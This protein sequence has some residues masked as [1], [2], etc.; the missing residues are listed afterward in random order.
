MPFPS[1]GTILVRGTAG[2]LNVTGSIELPA[3]L[4]PG[5]FREVSRSLHQRLP[6]TS[7]NTRKNVNRSQQR[8][9]HLK[10]SKPGGYAI[11]DSFSSKTSLPQQCGGCGALSQTVDRQDPG[12]YSITRRSVKNYLNGGYCDELKD[13]QKQLEN[14]IFQAS[15]QSLDGQLLQSLSID[16]TRSITSKESKSDMKCK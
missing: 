9:L 5:L 16:T 14:Q 7:S 1:I 11:P 6:L 13:S 12:F 15:L 4:C 8:L 10:S 3:F 2:R